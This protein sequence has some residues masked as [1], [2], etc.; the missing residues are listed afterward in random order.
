MVYNWRCNSK[1]S[2]MQNRTSLPHFITVVAAAFLGLIQP[3]GAQF[4][5]VTNNGAITITGYTGSSSSAIIPATTNGHPVT[6]IGNAA[7]GGDAGLASATIP[8]SVTNIG[9][10]A[11]FGTG[12]TNIAIPGSVIGISGN[13]FTSCDSLTNISVNATNRAFSSLNGVLFDKAQDTLIQY[14]AGLTIASYIIPGSVSTI[15]SDAFYEAAGVS[16]VTIPATVN[17][18]ED[19]AFANCFALST[20]YFGGNA[21]NLGSF[22]FYENDFGNGVTAYYVPGTTGWD[23]FSATLG[24]SLA[25]S[26]FWFLPNPE[27]ISSGPS[28]GVQNG[29]FGFIVS[30]AT[31]ATL[32]VDACSN[33]FRPV[34]LPISTNTVLATNGTA[35]FIDSQ[36]GS[37]PSRFY[38]VEAAQ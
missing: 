29:Q 37:F 3:A 1:R 24:Q 14:P 22:A 8:N 12:L 18:I 7:F 26:T 33:L 31:N 25:V 36:S 38:R 4:T 23:A 19:D 34:W 27:I 32:V 2:P 30:W 5:F 10:F 35:N 16:S 28:I 17:S 21:P 9:A 11:F 6:M 13:A 15:A 20:A